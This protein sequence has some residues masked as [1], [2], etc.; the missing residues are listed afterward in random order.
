MF[1]TFHR[2]RQVMPCNDQSIIIPPNQISL[3]LLHKVIK[4]TESFHGHNQKPYSDHVAQLNLAVI[5]PSN[6]NFTVIITNQNFKILF[7]NHCTSQP[8]P[9]GI[10]QSIHILIIMPNKTGLFWVFQ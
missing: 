1:K 2:R 9:Q 3:S 5:I 8:K 7:Y 4:T 10:I 6:Q